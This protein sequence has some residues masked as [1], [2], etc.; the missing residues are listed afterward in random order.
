MP[1]LGA[2]REIC[3]A[4]ATGHISK[5]GEA[6]A[7]RHNCGSLI[8]RVLALSSTEALTKVQPMCLLNIKKTPCPAHR[9]ELPAVV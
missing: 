1:E 8:A 6:V 3:A 9:N 2:S 5:R 4:E 7:G